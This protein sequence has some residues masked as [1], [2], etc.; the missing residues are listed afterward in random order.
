MK[1]KL[2]TK[3]VIRCK[4]RIHYFSIL[5]FISGY[6]FYAQ[7]I[8]VSGKITDTLQNPLSYANILAIPEAIDQDVRFAI[9]DNDG[10]YKLGL[11]KNQTYNI[12]VS[13]LGY[14]PQTINVTTTN[15][16]LIKNFILKENPDQL[17]EVTIK[18][19]PPIVVKKDTI[20][21]KVDAFATGEERK[22]R[23]VLK[24]LPGVEVDK[25][26]NVMVQGKK[27][28]KVLV[29][30]KTFFT[31]DSK[32]AVNNIPADAVDKVEIL[33]NYNDVAM[34]KG[35][36][37][38]EDM[39]MNIKLKEDK[40]KFTFG[41]VE[42]GAGIKNRYLVHPNLFYYS[43]KTN[44]NFIG[45]LNNQGIK[46]FSFRDYLEFEGGFSK[47]MNDA[48]SYFSL[49]NSDFA[50]YL[51]NQDYTAN[52]N[53]FGALNIRQSINN[54]TD[55]SGY[56]ITSKSKTET[57]S[58]TLND[59]L[60]FE[61]P[62]L[63]E[64]TVTNQLN[65]FFTIG[66]ITLEYNP[67]FNEDLTYNSFVKV[68]N[69]NSNGFITTL[70]PTEDNSITTLTDVTGV[71]LK[72]NIS[73]S[74]KLSKDHTVT[75]EA[76]YSYQ[77]DKPITEWLTNRQI[78][79]GLIPLIED[80]KYDIFQTKK[81]N[82]HSFNA[83]AKDYWVLNNFNHIYTS[84]GVNTAFN[85]FYNEDIQ[86]LTNGTINN[87]NSAGFD[88][89]FG[90]N[91][92]D[93]FMGLEYK[94]QIGIATFKPMLY[95][96]FYNWN[97]R[98]F[99]EKFSN[100]KTLLL[101]QFTTKIEFNNSEK[102][103]FK[104][105]LNARFPEIDRLANNFILNSFNS[106]FKGDT[107]LENQLYHSVNLSYYKFSLFKNLNLNINTSFNKKV[108]HFKSVTQLQG[109]NQFNTQILFDEPEYNWNLSGRISKKIN[110]I[111][112]NLSSRFSYNDFYQILNSD[113]NLNISKS[114]SSTF[115]IE[116]FFKN[117]PNIE[118]G[119][120]K[121]FSN[122]RS[123]GTITNFENDRFFVNL[124]YNFLKD[125]ILKADYSFDHYKNKNSTVNNTFDTANASLFY[126]KEDSPWG[127]EI[128]ATNLFNVTFKQQNSF[129]S[130]LIIDRK[131][132]ILPR[133]M[134]FK[135]AYKL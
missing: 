72:Q 132:F 37:D 83:T 135:I 49:F 19:T 73:Y 126:Q 75:L 61:S 1:K 128:N 127:F 78:L 57:Q 6:S 62:F 117:Y 11:S 14:K 42:V 48:G 68:T 133:I 54:V 112:Y 98:Q 20:T 123:I 97:T 30:N 86:K 88:N 18:Y 26:G 131:T 120:T 84:V 10:N 21:Y 74:R 107:T 17:D 29:E 85:S 25:L 46:S 63:E 9:T 121:D 134:M 109:I 22:L 110:K 12:T 92:V 101:P 4:A 55:I 41:D 7:N 95:Y 87:F 52:T 51:N 122:Y 15:Q 31:G 32:L 116:T 99:D 130:F 2:Y 56:V 91:F 43:P 58:E 89:D 129:N 102:I 34:L 66:K 105:Q 82:S 119:Y 94:F 16:D 104:Y 39:A 96:H 124:E 70:N 13:Y 59:Y 33:D 108:K 69:N 125:F 113:T 24:K 65:N 80:I 118:L 60:N 100:N 27:V 81:S 114:F 50:Q 79:Q 38:T 8:V 93:T 40:K 36:Q 35:L 45:D 106:V 77:N 76:T 3:F 111:R 115:S 103:N 90:Y 28:T 44:V 64:R 47:L 67:D 23:E 71:N 5:F 53:Q